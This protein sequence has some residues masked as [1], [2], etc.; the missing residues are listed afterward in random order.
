MPPINP[1]TPMQPPWNPGIRN[2]GNANN[3]M[4]QYTTGRIQNMFQNQNR[5][6]FGGG[7][8]R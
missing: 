3:L 7:I 1:P 2:G 8:G 4:R 6:G 5:G